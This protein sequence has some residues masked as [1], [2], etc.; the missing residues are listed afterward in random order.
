MQIKK[1]T[2]HMQYEI[3]QN[4]NTPQSESTFSNINIRWTLWLNLKIHT[5]M[6]SGHVFNHLGEPIGRWKTFCW[7]RFLWLGI[8]K[9]KPKQTEVRI[10]YRR[11]LSLIRISKTYHHFVT[12]PRA[13]NVMLQN[14]DIFGASLF[15][16]ADFFCLPTF[17]Q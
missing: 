11:N 3:M 12:A 17:P 15:L 9:E 10:L 5:K 6:I 2:I 13:E 14:V 8:D 16:D 1:S 7:K 4:K